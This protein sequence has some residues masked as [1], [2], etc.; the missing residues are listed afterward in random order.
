MGSRLWPS[1]VM[2][3]GLRVS[4][5]RRHSPSLKRPDC[6]EGQDRS[7]GPPSQANSPT[8]R[9]LWLHQGRLRKASERTTMRRRQRL[10]FTKRSAEGSVGKGVG[11]RVRGGASDKGG[12][13]GT[14]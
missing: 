12:T 5:S 3:I 1:K 13:Q 2:K 11:G 9:K 7:P 6:Q 10:R 8:H 4:S 14:E